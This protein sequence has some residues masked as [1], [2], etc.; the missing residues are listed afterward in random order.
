V[1]E[2]TRFVAFDLSFYQKE[3][4]EK[5]GRDSRK[6]KWDVT[7]VCVC[8]RARVRACVRVCVC[9]CARREWPEALIQRIQL[10]HL[11]A[12]LQHAFQLQ[13]ETDAVKANGLFFSFFFFLRLKPL[14]QTV[15]FPLTLALGAKKKKENMPQSCPAPSLRHAA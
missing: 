10:A 14:R 4:K 12:D 9:A 3:E 6:K 13:A 8:V 15:S 2:T 11:R 5:K 7:R 1:H